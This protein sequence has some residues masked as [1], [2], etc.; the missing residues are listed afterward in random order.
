MLETVFKRVQHVRYRPLFPP[1]II[2]EQT[3]SRKQLNPRGRALS[4]SNDPPP[5]K[6]NPLE[7]SDLES[8]MLKSSGLLDVR[9]PL[10]AARRYLRASLLD[11]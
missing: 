10:P 1:S 5:A 3:T 11:G 8:Y 9:P 2:Q 6:F 7:T 4:A